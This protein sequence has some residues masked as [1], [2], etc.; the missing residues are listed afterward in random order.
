MRMVSKHNENMLR[1]FRKSLNKRMLTMNLYV[2]LGIGFIFCL[3]FLTLFSLY[4]G[5][6]YT[7]WLELRSAGKRSGG[8]QIIQGAVFALLGLLLAFTFSGALAKFDRRRALII[9]EA[10]AISTLYLRLDLLP[11]KTQDLV[12]Q[13]LKNYLDLRIKT[14]R[15]F[16]NIRAARSYLAQSLNAQDKL[17]KDT[18][19]TC[20]QSNVLYTCMLIIPS[21]NAAFDLANM[22]VN[23]TQMHPPYFIFFFIVIVALI[24]AFLVGFTITGKKRA[25]PLHVVIFSFVVTMIIFSIIDMEY[26]RLGFIRVDSFDKALLDVQKKLNRSK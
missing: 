3:F 23:L 6:Q 25:S 18:I 15:A 5:R 4:L 8:I 10:N 12:K 1:K 11:L 2:S 20:S 13:D 14:Y 9:E 22:R 7:V 17:W 16:P 19:A 21:L 24:S 26:P